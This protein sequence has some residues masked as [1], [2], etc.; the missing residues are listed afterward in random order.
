MQPYEAPT[1]GVR[2]ALKLDPR[3]GGWLRDDLPNLVLIYDPSDPTHKKTV[4]H[5][6]E[7]S[8]FKCGANLFNCFR[9]DSRS[10]PG[11]KKRD[12]VLGA[13]TRSGDLVA[14]VKGT[15][16]LRG[17]WHILRKALSDDRGIDLKRLMPSL[18][19][20]LSALCHAKAHIKHLNGRL[21]DPGTGRLDAKVGRQLTSALKAEFGWQR[22]LSA[23]KKRKV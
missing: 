3:K 11:D 9:V 6:E 5:L 20:A 22:V 4:R 16:R 14:S 13:Y 8:R 21:I 2:D 17:A 23:L 12:V 1:L 19:E 18:Q 7:D 10:L 15:S